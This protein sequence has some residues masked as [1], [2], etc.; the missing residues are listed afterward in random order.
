MLDDT[1]RGIR[2]KRHL[3]AH[4]CSDDTPHALNAEQHCAPH[5]WFTLAP[6]LKLE[7]EGVALL[8]LVTHTTRQQRLDASTARK[9]KTRHGFILQGAQTKNC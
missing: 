7:S 8:L 3:F 1:L 6:Q 4:Q 5:D 9:C 2:L